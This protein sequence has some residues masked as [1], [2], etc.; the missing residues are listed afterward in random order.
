MDVVPNIETENVQ[1]TALVPCTFYAFTLKGVNFYVRKKGVIPEKDEERESYFAADQI[2]IK[3]PYGGLEDAKP[4]LYRRTPTEYFPWILEERVKKEF[5]YLEG[6]EE[7]K[8][9]PHN[10]AGANIGDFFHIAHHNFDAIIAFL[11]ENECI[12]RETRMLSPKEK[13]RLT[14]Y[15]LSTNYVAVQEGKGDEDEG[16][17]FM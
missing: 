12:K 16:G 1:E 7:P 3:L 14:F 4:P 13:E 8:Y 2:I 6:T 17:T 9:L 10:I 15:Q 11:L 5:D